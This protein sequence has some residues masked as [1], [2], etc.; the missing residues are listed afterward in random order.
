MGR[1]ADA[2][3]A[4]YGSA[5]NSGLM[6][7]TKFRKALRE[8]DVSSR[9]LRASKKA[10][11]TAEHNSAQEFRRA[12]RVAI[13]NTPQQYES[14]CIL[15]KRIIVDPSTLSVETAADVHVVF[16]ARPGEVDKIFLGSNGAVKGV[17]KKGGEAEYE[18]VSAIGGQ[19]ARRFLTTYRDQP[20]ALRSVAIRELARYVKEILGLDTVGDL[21]K[22]GAA[23]AVRAAELDGAA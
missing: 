19:L 7:L 16:S 20:Q 2:L 15:K 22:I 12:V 21:R 17:L 14:I 18:I 4:Y 10:V 23:L 5:T 11:M 13:A 9:I 3:V 1:V 8:L 6:A